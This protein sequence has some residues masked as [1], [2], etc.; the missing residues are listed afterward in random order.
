MHRTMEHPNIVRVE[1]TYMNDEEVHLL[2]ERQEGGELFDTIV[3]SGGM[4]EQ[5][6]ARIMVQLLS[7]LGYL[8]AQRIVHRDLKPE[9]VLFSTKDQDDVVIIDFGFATKCEEGMLMQR[10]C[11]TLHYAAPEVIS[12]CAYSE[13]VDMWSLGAIAYAMMTSRP[14]Y[15]G[16]F[17]DIKRK[18]GTGRIDFC[19]AFEGRLSQG[20]RSFVRS[21]LTVDPRK[22]SDVL[23]AL[24]HPWLREHAPAQADAALREVC[25]SYAEH[26]ASHYSADAIL[27]TV[28]GV[29]AKAKAGGPSCFLGMLAW[30]R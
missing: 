9:N 19:S 1:D 13:K 6:A 29:R 17:A 22:R 15:T 20:A 8:H 25:Q 3:S 23:E 18:A 7:A 12:G 5:R 24:A 28:E 30:C 11:G 21:L 27:Q 26:R 14:L 2:M 16:S 10:R 4:T